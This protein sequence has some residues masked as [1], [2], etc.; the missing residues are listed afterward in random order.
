MTLLIYFYSSGLKVVIID[1]IYWSVEV[2]GLE[3]VRVEVTPID[4]I[5]FK[6]FPLEWN[7]FQVLLVFSPLAVVVGL[8]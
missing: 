7:R 3:A 1:M 5:C 2:S 8:S 6:D 4:L